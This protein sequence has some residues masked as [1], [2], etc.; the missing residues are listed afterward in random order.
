MTRRTTCRR[1]PVVL[2]LGALTTVAVAWV[3]FVQGRTLGPSWPDYQLL[4]VSFESGETMWYAVSTRRA[5]GQRDDHLMP[6]D[7]ADLGRTP[8]SE[9]MARLP[10][11]ANPPTKRLMGSMHAVG[12]GW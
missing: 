6:L 12:T 10:D 7:M 5:F 4:R 9:E 1:L 11:W 8:A 3:M 2:A